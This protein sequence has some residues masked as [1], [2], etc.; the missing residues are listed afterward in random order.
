MISRCFYYFFYEDC[1]AS[2]ILNHLGEGLRLKIE[3]IY[4]YDGG[5]NKEQ[6]KYKD[7]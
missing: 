4:S 3:V 5:V 7:T 6:N 1:T 2:I